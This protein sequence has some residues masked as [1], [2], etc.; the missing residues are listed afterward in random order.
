MRLH[1]IVMGSLCVC[2]AFALGCGG[3]VNVE[4]RVLM[5][6]KPVGGAQVLFIP[7]NGGQQAGDVTDDAGHFQLK[8]PQKL[9]IVPGEYVVTVSKKDFPPGMKRPSPHELT[10]PLAAKMKETLPASYTQ[11]DKT[12]LRITIPSGGTN[13]LV[14]DIK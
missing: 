4:G 11:L 13:D 12:P 2:S 7:V 8:N 5:D 14:L 9:G 1:K 3:P 6:G 10:I